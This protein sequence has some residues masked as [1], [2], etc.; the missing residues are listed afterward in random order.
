[1]KNNY[2]LYARLFPTILTAIPMIVFYA[3]VI[4]PIV[5]K[6]LSVVWEY[7]PMLTDISVNAAFIFLLVMVNRY[8]SKV[9]FQ[10]YYLEDELKMP[11][12]EWL[13]PNSTICDKST[14]NRIYQLIQKDLNIDL[15]KDL[16]SL[17]NEN[18]KRKHVAQ[19]VGIIRNGLRDNTMLLQ[20]NIEYGFFRNLIG[21]SILA[22]LFSIG[23][24]VVSTC[25]NDNGLLWTGIVMLGLYI[26]PIVLSKRI[27]RAHGENYASVFFK[28]YESSKKSQTL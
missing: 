8:L 25:D 2:Y 15:R 20:H 18:D 4:H 13:L 5:E 16:K 9:I 17:P 26:L 12:T 23:I 21:G 24:I 3:N 28:E 22:V 1:M 10:K 7:L 11:T 14:R 19:V 27:I 6:N